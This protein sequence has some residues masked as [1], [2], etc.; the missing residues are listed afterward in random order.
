MSTDYDCWKEDEETVSWKLIQKIMSNNS[1]NVLD[2]FVNTIP[3]L[4]NLG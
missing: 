4:K 1:S 3:Q 2:I